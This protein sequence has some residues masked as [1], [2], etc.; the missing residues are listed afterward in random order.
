MMNQLTQINILNLSSKVITKI[1]TM[2][3]DKYLLRL[4]EIC[5]DAKDKVDSSILD[6][7][8]RKVLIELCTYFDEFGCRS[9]TF[10]RIAMLKIRAEV[11]IIT[12]KAHQDR[13][14][15]RFNNFS[16]FLNIYSKDLRFTLKLEDVDTFLNRIRPRIAGVQW[17][18]ICMNY[19]ALDIIRTFANFF[20]GMYVKE[21]HTSP[22]I[23]K[24][25]YSTW[26]TLIRN[27]IAA[28]FSCVLS[29]AT[30]GIVV[31]EISAMNDECCKFIFQFFHRSD[32][33]L[34]FNA[35]THAKPVDVQVGAYSFYV[36]EWQPPSQDGKRSVYIMP[37][38]VRERE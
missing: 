35:F 18:R 7:E 4:R 2:I 33:K 10:L 3:D 14:F 19:A 36:Y 13:N 12:V 28:E 8:D 25:N 9:Y 34:S 32:K 30:K 26:L 6:T 5:Y 23:E 11:P 31:S 38:E 20:N 22:M 21:I 17:R 27:V 29:V 1:F 37:I 16:N 15:V 24:S